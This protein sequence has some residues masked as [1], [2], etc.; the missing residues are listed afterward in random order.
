MNDICCM[1]VYNFQRQLW[2]ITCFKTGLILLTDD[3]KGGLPSSLFWSIHLR[4]LVTGSSFLV[5]LKC[6][7]ISWKL[8]RHLSRMSVKNPGNISGRSLLLISRFS[9]TVEDK[10]YGPLIQLNKTTALLST[11]IVLYEWSTELAGKHGVRCVTTVLPHPLI[12]GLV[13]MCVCMRAWVCVGIY[14]LDCIKEWIFFLF[15]WLFIRQPVT[16]AS[17]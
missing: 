8:K 13:T 3:K 14:V 11:R 12:Q 6:R 2:N 17:V 5:H 16:K 4:N 10:V 9:R 7:Q 1:K 15:L